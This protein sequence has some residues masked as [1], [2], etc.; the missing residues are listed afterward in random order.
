MQL[1]RQGEREKGSAVHAVREAKG[2]R[3]VHAW[4]CVQGCGDVYVYVYGS[5]C[6]RECVRS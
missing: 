3:G 1:V 6:M 2:Q 5:V 4:V